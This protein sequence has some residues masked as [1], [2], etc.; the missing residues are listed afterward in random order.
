MTPH[1]ECTRPGA[2]IQEAAAKM[3]QLD[4]GPLPVCDDDHHPLG[5][6]TDRD[7]TIRAVAEGKDPGRTHV[8]EVMTPEVISCF[9][10]Q[11]VEEA[12]D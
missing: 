2:T 3:R 7:I 12:C 5:M 1:V 11:D 9:D 10:D 8:H 6:V 4:I